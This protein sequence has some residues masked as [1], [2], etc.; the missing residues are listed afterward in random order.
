MTHFKH[1]IKNL[2]IVYFHN[3]WH[4]RVSNTHKNC[5]WKWLNDK[6]F[7]KAHVKGDITLQTRIGLYEDM[8]WAVILD[9]LKFHFNA[10]CRRSSIQKL[11]TI[12]CTVTPE[13]HLKLLLRVYNYHLK[14]L[15]TW[16]QNKNLVELQV[17]LRYTAAERSYLFCWIVKCALVSPFRRRKYRF[18]LQHTHTC[19]NMN[20]VQWK[21]S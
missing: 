10:K 4:L 19:W 1:K 5:H 2:F 12:D 9:V 14:I 13:H 3:I 17:K 21:E 15:D 16:Q 6:Y 11:V 18:C 8:S 20:D 7:C